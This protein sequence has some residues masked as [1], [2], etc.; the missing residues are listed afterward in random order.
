MIPPRARRG[1]VSTS[2]DAQIPGMVPEGRR[3]NWEISAGAVLDGGADGL[4]STAPNNVFET[5]ALFVP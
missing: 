2:A 4:A 1:G 3:A 5:Q